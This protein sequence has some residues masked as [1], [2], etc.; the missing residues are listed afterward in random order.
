MSGD[1]RLQGD[2]GQQ[3]QAV[4]LESWGLDSGRA[5]GRMRSIYEIIYV[6]FS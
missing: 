2:A 5:T 6:R 1:G 4:G 3:E